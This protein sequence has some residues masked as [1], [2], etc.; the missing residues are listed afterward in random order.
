[1]AVCALALNTAVLVSGPA[2]AAAIGPGDFS[3]AATVTTFDGLGL[4]IHGNAT[5][6]TLDGNTYETDNGI[7]RYLGPSFCPGE[8]FGTDTDSGF[9]DITFGTAYKLVGL[10]AGPGA[11]DPGAIGEFWSATVEFFNAS[12][13]LVGNIPL[14]GGQP[15]A[16]EF[17]GWEDA[18]GIASIRITDTAT[19]GLVVLINDV[20]FEAPVPLPAAAWLFG[21][22]V[23]ALIGIARKRNAA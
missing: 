7:F 15:A 1:M 19:N 6:Y 22:G 14:S 16:L 5:P 18:S 17:A 21:S 2:M 9:I 4:P 20:T 23:L 3:A 10:Y 13:V 12:N 8:C 11:N